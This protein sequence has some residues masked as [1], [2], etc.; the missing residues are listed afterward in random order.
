MVSF[1]GTLVK[2][3]FTKDRNSALK[4]HCN[5][6]HHTID[7]ECVKILT[8]D[9]VKSRLFVKEALK[10]REFNAHLSLNRNVRGCEL[11]LW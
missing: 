7:F 11:K 4:D 3:L 9:N 10:I 8:S 6:S 5:T 1:S 2:S